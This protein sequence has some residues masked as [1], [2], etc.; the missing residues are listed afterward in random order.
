MN[1]FIHEQKKIVT[2]S[3]NENE[4]YSIIG[5]QD[6]LDSKNNPRVSSED[7]IKVVAKK[8]YRDDGSIRYSIKYENGKF[9][10]PISIYGSKV[11]NTFLDRICKSNDKFKEVNPKA[12]EMYLK[13]LKTKNTAWLNNVE[14]E[15]I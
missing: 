3:K 9:T 1:N 15:I 11:E 13:F 4:F 14:R 2:N 10:N 6:F 7:D 8:I 12:F 5:S